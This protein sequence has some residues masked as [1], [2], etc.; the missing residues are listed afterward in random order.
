MKLTHCNYPSV[1]IPRMRSRNQLGKLQKRF[2]SNKKIRSSV[3]LNF[4]IMWKKSAECVFERRVI[5]KALVKFFTQM[6]K[7][8]YFVYVLRTDLV[9]NSRLKLVRIPGVAQL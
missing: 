7:I 3:S 9:E 2:K 8:F 1:L 6:V 4:T 5:R